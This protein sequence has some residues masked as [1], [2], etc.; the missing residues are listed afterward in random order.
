MAALAWLFKIYPLRVWAPAFA[1]VTEQLKRSAQKGFTRSWRSAQKGFTLIE[2]LVALAV[3][4]LAALALV[5]LEG[6]TLKSVAGVDRHVMGQIVA[7]NL[8]VAMLSDPRAPGIGQE[9]GVI[10]NGGQ[11]WRW[12]RV[13][14]RTADPRLVRIDISVTDIE[15]APAAALTLARP[16][17]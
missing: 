5:R 7:N 2:M 13:T 17:L 16:V 14:R 11:S 1:G 3:F 4:G 15:G 8:A 10:E 12:S 6:A 9:A